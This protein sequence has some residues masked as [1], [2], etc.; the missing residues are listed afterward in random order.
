MKTSREGTEPD[1]E[2]DLVRDVTPLS[3]TGQ[4]PGA[5]G[6]G[7]MEREILRRLAASLGDD[8]VSERERS[9]GRTAL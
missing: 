7:G 1:S 3:R 4:A 6:R 5:A 9:G 2:D 8:G